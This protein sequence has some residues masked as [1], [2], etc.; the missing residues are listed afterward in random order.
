MTKSEILA[1]RDLHNAYLMQEHYNNNVAPVLQENQNL[2]YVVNALDTAP[3]FAVIQSI[4][5]DEMGGMQEHGGD[6]LGDTP[7]YDTENNYIEF[8]TSGDRLYGQGYYS[9]DPYTA[10]RQFIAFGQGGP[11]TYPEPASISDSNVEGEIIKAESERRYSAA[12]DAWKTDTG[13]GLNREGGLIFNHWMDDPS[14]MPTASNRSDGELS[15]GDTWTDPVTGEVYTLKIGTH[16]PA[17]Y[18]YKAWTNST[19]GGY[20]NEH[21]RTQIS[22]NSGKLYKDWGTMAP[23]NLLHA[24][25][26]TDSSNTPNSADYQS[27]TLYNSVTGT[28]KNNKQALLAQMQKPDYEYKPTGTNAQKQQDFAR[29][30]NTG[31]GAA[32][33]YNATQDPSDATQLIQ[34]EAKNIKATVLGQALQDKNVSQEDYDRVTTEFFDNYDKNKTANVLEATAGTK[35]AP[36]AKTK[37][38][39]KAESRKQRYA[40]GMKGIQDATKD[41]FVQQ[42]AKD[43]YTAINPASSRSR[44][45]ARGNAPMDFGDVITMERQFAKGDFGKDFEY[46]LYNPETGILEH[47]YYDVLNPTASGKVEFASDLAGSGY[48]EITAET[49]TRPE[50]ITPS[51]T[52]WK[53]SDD[54]RFSGGDL[55]DPNKSFGVKIG[56]T[57]VDIYRGDNHTLA[58]PALVEEYMQTYFPDEKAQKLSN[59]EIISNALG[60]KLDFGGG[61]FYA[62]EFDTPEFYDMYPYQGNNYT[63][64]R[65]NKVFRRINQAAQDAVM[66]MQHGVGANGEIPTAYE[67]LST[68]RDAGLPVPEGMDKFYESRGGGQTGTSADV[69]FKTGYERT[70]PNVGE[71]DTIRYADPHPAVT[72]EGYDPLL[73]NTLYSSGGTPFAEFRRP[74]GSD[75]NTPRYMSDRNALQN[76]RLF[77]PSPRMTGFFQG[78]PIDTPRDSG[79]DYVG[80]YSA[81]F[82]QSGSYPGQSGQIGDIRLQQGA[83]NNYADVGAIANTPFMYV[84]EYDA[85]LNPNSPYTI[86]A[87]KAV[88]GTSSHSVPDDFLKFEGMTDPYQEK[89]GDT[90]IQRRFKYTGD[91][92]FGGVAGGRADYSGISSRDALYEDFEDNII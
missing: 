24:L 43:F 83:G 68:L 56:D 5:T 66:F 40:Q 12:V 64:L 47:G 77:A 3:N 57:V 27:G 71:G 70:S 81:L 7:Y 35:Y 45:E 18:K 86:S 32:F 16:G 30:L 51:F 48:G 54:Q 65:D 20:A 11:S 79:P 91:T 58:T 37:S 9:T 38:Q 78:A 62:Q 90:S 74:L 4:V 49:K 8:P 87:R 53:L 63:M 19:T 92:G 17:G 50:S 76:M 14:M 67:A 52:G 26:Y 60:G 85:E 29:F 72:D 31:A 1:L 33:F 6:T 23:P 15:H 21:G 75:V 36:K 41:M 22:D 34:N 25:G 73:I 44:Q 39:L 59:A 42:Q 10:T 82:D 28:A 69:L 2:Q 13:Y 46:D 80:G 88:Y 89:F 55:Q 61:K 84:D